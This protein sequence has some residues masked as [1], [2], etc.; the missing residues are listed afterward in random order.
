MSV[1]IKQRFSGQVDEAFLM[2]PTIYNI[3]DICKNVTKCP[4]AWEADMPVYFLPTEQ[5][6][7][8]G[9]FIGEPD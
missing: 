4:P 5:T 1:I 2:C 8:Y 9:R 7:S 6:E 3:S